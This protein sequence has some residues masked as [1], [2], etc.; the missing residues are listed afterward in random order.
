MRDKKTIWLIPSLVITITLALVW[1]PT[2]RQGKAQIQNSQVAGGG[3]FHCNNGAVSGKYTYHLIGKLAGVGDAAVIGTFTQTY[4]G[5]FT[6]QHEAL[7]FN[8]QIPPRPIPYSGTFSVNS[9]CVGMGDFTETPTPATC[10]RA[11]PS[12]LT[13]IPLSAQRFDNALHCN[14]QMTTKGGMD[15][16]ATFLFCASALVCCSPWR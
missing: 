8:G 1:T 2:L 12:G 7:S 5:T 10:F 16:C 6:G 3:S 4:D 13:E 14:R 9:N 11:S 15:T